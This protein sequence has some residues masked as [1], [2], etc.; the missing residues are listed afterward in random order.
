MK[1]FILSSFSYKCNCG[2]EV[3][4]SLDSGMPQE[5]YKCRKCGSSVYRKQL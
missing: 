5:K 4:V 2:F 1:Q 3:L